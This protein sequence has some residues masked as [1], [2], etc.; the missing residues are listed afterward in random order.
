MSTASKVDDV[1]VVGFIM[2]LSTLQGR[3]KTIIQ[4]MI[5]ANGIP[6]DV[7]ETERL[8]S[9]TVSVTSG[10]PSR[11]QTFGFYIFLVLISILLI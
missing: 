6:R 7:F 5:H 2:P 10:E 9:T 11:E 8:Q 4:T 1:E 3:L